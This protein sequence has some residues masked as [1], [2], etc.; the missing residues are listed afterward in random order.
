MWKPTTK[1]LVAFLGILVQMLYGGADAGF[2]GDNEAWVRPV[3]G[4]V[5]AAGIYF[6]PDLWPAPSAWERFEDEI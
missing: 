4:A 5:S 6:V 3:L 1:A 2:L